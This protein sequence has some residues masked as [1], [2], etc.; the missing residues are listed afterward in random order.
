MVATGIEKISQSVCGV[1]KQISACGV[2][3]QICI[4]EQVK[5]VMCVCSI[6]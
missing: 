6:H 1:W 5:V 2:P 4:C 3:K